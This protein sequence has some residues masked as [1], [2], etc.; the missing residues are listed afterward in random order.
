MSMMATRYDDEG[1]DALSPQHS[2]MDDNSPSHDDDSVSGRS[3]KIRKK[4]NAYQKIDDDIRVK[5]LESVQ[6]NGETLKSAAKRFN[7]NYSSAKSILHTYRKEGRILKKSAQDRTMKKRP[8]QIPP[9]DLAQQMQVQG[10]SQC[11]VLPNQRANFRQNLRVNTGRGDLKLENSNSPNH[12]QGESSPMN[13]L[14]DKFGNLLQLNHNNLFDEQQQKLLKAMNQHGYLQQI[15]RFHQQNEMRNDQRSGQIEA[16]PQGQPSTHTQIQ[17]NSSNENAVDMF[18][19]MDNFYMNYSNSPLSSERIL[20]DGSSKSTGA[21]RLAK[22]F[23]SF[24]DMISALQAKKSS[25]E[26]KEDIHIPRPLRF[27]TAQKLQEQIE[28]IMHNEDDKDWKGTIENAALDTFRT[29][30][31]A[32]LLLCDALK[33][34]NF[35]NN[36]VQI[37]KTKDQDPNASNLAG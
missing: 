11:Q 31:D 27:N 29:V 2:N 17:Q 5:L 19:M 21:N 20:K 8:D 35:L 25:E 12:I 32:Q 34:A 7:I 13:K 24:S 14:T 6:H 26:I 10:L 23:D 9:Q 33:K 28:A 37:Q 22:E 16:S 30:V 3:K 1:S 36:L 15:S 18:K 4:R